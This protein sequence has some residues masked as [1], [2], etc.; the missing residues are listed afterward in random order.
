MG[1]SFHNINPATKNDSK[2]VSAKV[3]GWLFDAI[4]AFREKYS[5]G[6]RNATLS[7]LIS[8]GLREYGF[9]SNDECKTFVETQGMADGQQKSDE[10]YGSI[11]EDSNEIC[12]D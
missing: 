5:F 2:V 1:I 10:H 7:V 9:L 11:P 6:T 4:E 8:V 12:Q 3:D